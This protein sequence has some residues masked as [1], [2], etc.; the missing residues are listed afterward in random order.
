MA[1][2]EP[3]RGWKGTLI[4]FLE[5][6]AAKDQTQ[7]PQ[8][9]KVVT[10]QTDVKKLVESIRQARKD[11]DAAQ[12]KRADLTSAWLEYDQEMIEDVEATRQRL[13]QLQ[14]QF[15]KVADECGLE[16]HLPAGAVPQPEHGE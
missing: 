8:Q 15:A 11:L 3:T 9:T 12:H 7:P 16:V 5:S 13:F 14:V 4:P 6:I 1:R 2:Q 10:L